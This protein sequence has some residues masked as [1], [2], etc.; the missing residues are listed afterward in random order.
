MISLLGFVSGKLIAKQQGVSDDNSNRLAILGAVMGFTPLS[1]A[2]TMMIAKQEAPLP[3]I[4]PPTTSTHPVLGSGAAT[5]GPTST[6]NPTSTGTTS[7]TST[8]PSATAQAV[9]MPNLVGV[10]ASEAKKQFASLFPREPEIVESHIINSASRGTIINTF[11][12]ANAT[13][14]PTVTAIS[15]LVSSGPTS[16][17]KGEAEKSEKLPSRV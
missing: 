2:A 13:F 5:N 9:V 12:A 1:V 3:V 4:V 16:A 7:S 17:I 15:F 14:D 10:P 6:S 11:P 8:T